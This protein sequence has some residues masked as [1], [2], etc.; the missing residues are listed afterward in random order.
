MKRHSHSN[1][2]TQ[3]HPGNPGQEEEAHEPTQQQLP[4]GVT[5]TFP[6]GNSGFSLEK[7]LLY[8]GLAKI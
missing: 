8:Q 3:V 7:L 4:R 5:A 1:E 6:N 2:E